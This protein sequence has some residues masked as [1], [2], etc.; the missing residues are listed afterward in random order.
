MLPFIEIGSF[1]MSSYIFM[2]LVAFLASTA[3]IVLRRKAQNVAAW[4]AIALSCTDRK[5]VV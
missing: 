5:S 1:R 4:E 3:L 2:A